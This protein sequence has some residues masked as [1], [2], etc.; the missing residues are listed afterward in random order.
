MTTSARLSAVL[1]S[2]FNAFVDAGVSGSADSSHREPSSSVIP[3]SVAWD[4]DTPSNPFKM[5]LS[6]T[7]MAA[8]CAL[9]SS[10][11]VD[12]SCSLRDA[13]AKQIP[14]VLYLNILKALPKFSQSMRCIWEGTSDVL[15]LTWMYQCVDEHGHAAGQAAKDE[16]VEHSGLPGSYNTTHFELSMR[17]ILGNDLQ[18]SLV[19][20]V[21]E[22]CRG[23]SLKE[24][25]S[26][27]NKHRKQ[28]Q[29][30]VDLLDGP[31][32]SP[33][34]VEAATAA[35]AA[36]VA[37]TR[38][39]MSES[40]FGGAAAAGPDTGQQLDNPM[41]KSSAT[42]RVAPEEKQAAKSTRRELQ[43]L[44]GFMREKGLLGTFVECSLVALVAKVQA[45]E[46]ESA[47]AAKSSREAA[48]LA[49]FLCEQL[50]TVDAPTADKFA[51]QLHVAVTT[52]IAALHAA[53]GGN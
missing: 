52:A 6:I 29:P 15:G 20:L 13:E 47:D 8:F 28:T 51:A 7:F 33:E 4:F 49:Y 18:P 23:A 35:A 32:L 3:S 17:T 22:E 12:V 31:S 10:A 46:L 38:P 26:S 11:D 21:R 34:G 43:R 25:E 36:V 50:R 24:F 44:A 41:K 9:C 16:V 48:K 19:G 40:S 45:E 39:A 53:V 30:V 5:W 1:N 27:A 14:G 42:I 37:T 2:D